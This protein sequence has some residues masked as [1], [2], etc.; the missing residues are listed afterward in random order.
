[1]RGLPPALKRS[2]SDFSFAYRR[3]M[4]DLFA[5]APDAELRS[6]D[7]E[8][9]LF[10]ALD[11]ETIA[12]EFSRPLW[13]HGGRRDT[14]HLQRSDV[15]A[16]IA[17]AAEAMGASRELAVLVFEDPAELAVRFADFIA[18]YWRARFAEEWERVEPLLAGTVAESGRRIAV[19]GVYEFLRSVSLKLRVDPRREEFG[20]DLPHDHR[21]AVTVDRP[22]VL[23]PSAYVWPHVQVNCDEPWPLTLIYPAPIVARGAQAALPPDEL[24]RVLRTLGDQ[25]RLR[26]LKL[27]AE[28]PRSTQELAPLVGISEAGLSKHLRQLS[29]AGLVRSRREGYYVLYS[30]VPERIEPL[31]DALQRFL[32]G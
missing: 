2:I 32:R 8:L 13:D 29:D 19:D 3:H 26:T 4:P 14:T 25:T 15:R 31:S 1:M 22:L 17:H 16:Q 21:V 11:P 6:F 9:A 24:V 28:R 30:I 5:P 7:E 18:S 23:V 20:L 27:I 10:S 12:L